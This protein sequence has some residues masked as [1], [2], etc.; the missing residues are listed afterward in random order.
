MDMLYQFYIRNMEQAGVPEAGVIALWYILPFC[1]TIAAL[2]IVIL[3]MFIVERKV[4]LPVLNKYKKKNTETE[5]EEKNPQT[6]DCNLPDDSNK[7]LYLSAISLV[8]VPVIMAWGMVPYSNKYIPV[9]SGV[10]LLLFLSIL[11]LPVCGILLA[12][13]AGRNNFSLASSVRSSAITIS[14]V[15]PMMI[16]VIGVVVLSSSLN[17]NEIILGQSITA[18]A[19]G[20]YVLP[21]FIGFLVLFTGIIVQVCYVSL[22]YPV[23]KNFAIKSDAKYSGI[24]PAILNAL[25]YAV[26]FIMALF[27]V[28]LFFGGYLPPL[29]FYLS[30]VYEFNYSFNTIAVYF[31]QIFWLI[32]KTIIVVFVIMWVRAILPEIRDG[33][34][35]KFAWKWLLPLSV[36]NFC[37]VCV[38]KYLAGGFV[39]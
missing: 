29:G 15:V 30:E 26:I 38:Y 4:I 17:I 9:P 37:A 13:I 35:V 7:L 8:L 25:E 31:E 36:L 12:G 6:A 24:K 2:I 10:N 3:L 22:K 39:A 16:S 18:G 1:L 33:R 21:S 14:Y 5:T 20:W 32:A 27:L 19:F 11:I 23:V 34:I 28:C